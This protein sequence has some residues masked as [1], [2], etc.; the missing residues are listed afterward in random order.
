MKQ[1]IGKAVPVVF[2]VLF[3]GGFVRLGLYAETAFVYHSVHKTTDSIQKPVVFN[4]KGLVTSVDAVRDEVRIDTG[5]DAPFVVTNILT[6][7][8]WMPG[9]GDSLF[10]KANDTKVDTFMVLKKS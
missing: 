7:T 9:K 6:R 2:A 8:P 4:I 10:V 1:K 3:I 5:A